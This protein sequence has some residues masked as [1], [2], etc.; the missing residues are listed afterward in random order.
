MGL[1]YVTEFDPFPAK[2][3]RSE[4]PLL[5]SAQASLAA[6]ASELADTLPKLSLC[7]TGA[8]FVSNA[9]FMKAD[10][11]HVHA[12]L[13][14]DHGDIISASNG[15]DIEGTQQLMDEARSTI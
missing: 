14:R 8:A 6:A 15:I 2:S 11:A 12:T 5:E 10:A 1:S 7:R 3:L 4:V 9:N 13:A